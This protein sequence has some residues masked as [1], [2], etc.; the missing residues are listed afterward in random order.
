MPDDGFQKFR[1]CPPLRRW[2]ECDPVHRPRP[3]VKIFENRLPDGRIRV[4]TEIHKEPAV[5]RDPGRSQLDDLLSSQS[6]LRSWRTQT[7]RDRRHPRMRHRHIRCE[8]TDHIGRKKFLS[9]RIAGKVAFS[10]DEDDFFSRQAKALEE[11]QD[12]VDL[13]KKDLG[14]LE[15]RIAARPFVAPEGPVA[16]ISPGIA[17]QNLHKINLFRVPVRVYTN[18]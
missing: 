18:L 4:R 15:V 11:F 8:P 17:G 14:G 3:A 12:F 2:L 1:V 6:C 5:A 16:P 9:K 7:Q 13:A 10:R